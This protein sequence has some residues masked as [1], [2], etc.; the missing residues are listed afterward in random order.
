M[1]E[2]EPAT[3]EGLA[4]VRVFH[5]Y[6]VDSAATC[7]AG[8]GKRTAIACLEDPVLIAKIL[9]HVR[10]REAL[11]DTTPRAPPGSLPVRR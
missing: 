9:A 6:E 10:R 2:D 7:P 3:R 5:G 11:F 1:I 8:G 4:D